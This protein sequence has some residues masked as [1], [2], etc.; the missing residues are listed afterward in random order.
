V[1]RIAFYKSSHPQPADILPIMEVAL[2]LS[3]LF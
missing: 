2:N 1:P 3:N